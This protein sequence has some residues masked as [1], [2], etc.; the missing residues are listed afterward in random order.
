MSAS[1]ES[2]F[3][4]PNR[5][6]IAVLISGSGTTLKN[7]LDRQQAGNC[8]IDIRLVISSKTTAGGLAFAHQAKIHTEIVRRKDCES[9][10]AHRDQLFEHLRASN[11][12]YVV[13]GGYLEHLLIAD[14]FENRVLNIHPS[15]IPSFCG[16]GFYGLRVHQAALDYGVKISG[17]TV[18]FVDDHFD[19]GPIIAQQI[20][21]VEPDDTAET[22]QRRVFEQECELL[23]EVLT[24]L[25]TRQIRIEDRTI[26]FE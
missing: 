11:I 12:K 15:L 7:L 6:P 9:P 26:R 19:H 10:E 25:A 4:A 21:H 14:D 5:L 18:H 17:C 8:P 2:K 22:L 13:M 1:S 24:G 16:K 20:C 23:P 3:E